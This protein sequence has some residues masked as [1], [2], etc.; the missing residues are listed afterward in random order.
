[1]PEK[2]D[3]R[4]ALI[5]AFKKYKPNADPAAVARKDFR[6]LLRLSLNDLVTAGSMALDRRLPE[7][8]SLFAQEII[9]TDDGVPFRPELRRLVSDCLDDDTR[10]RECLN[11][12]KANKAEVDPCVYGLL[13]PLLGT[14]LSEWDI[15][16]KTNDGFE[17]AQK[18]STKKQ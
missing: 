9:R 3:H 14:L 12:I 6:A 7:S 11:Y 17:T 13:F 15:H 18:A 4:M 2:E 8:L 1:M 16:S 10:A 5:K